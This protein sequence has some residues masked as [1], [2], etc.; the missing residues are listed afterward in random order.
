MKCLQILH[1]EAFHIDSEIACMMVNWTKY[2]IGLAEYMLENYS[3]RNL[4][5]VECSAAA[6][7]DMKSV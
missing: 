1:L 5:L 4:L 7:T 6:S 3:Q 2:R